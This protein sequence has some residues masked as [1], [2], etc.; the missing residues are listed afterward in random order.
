[1]ACIPVTF[2]TFALLVAGIVLG[3]A[4]CEAV[5]WLWSRR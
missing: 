5:K 3:R 2:G 1:M 4:V